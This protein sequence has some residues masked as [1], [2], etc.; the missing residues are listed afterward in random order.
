[1]LDVTSLSQKQNDDLAAGMNAVNAYWRSV[2]N[3]PRFAP[4]NSLPIDRCILG[5]MCVN[6]ILH[7][8]GRKDASVIRTGLE[9]RRTSLSDGLSTSYTIGDPTAPVIPDCINGHWVVRLG[10]ILLDPTH[11][12]TRQDWNMSPFAAAFLCETTDECLVLSDGTQ[13]G[14]IATHCLQKADFVYRSIFFELS[15]CIR[16][17]TRKWK[18]V[19]DAQPKARE[20][21]VRLAILNMGNLHDNDNTQTRSLSRA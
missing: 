20:H 8:A 12:Q 16:Q 4:P 19:P 13:A 18:K 9:V 3:V 11:G 7:I 5:A 2:L 15:W 14:V 6:D 17:Q 10:D 21:L 1:M